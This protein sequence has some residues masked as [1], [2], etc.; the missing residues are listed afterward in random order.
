MNNDTGALAPAADIHDRLKHLGFE[1]DER[2]EIINKVNELI[3]A[4]WLADYLAS[5]P[6]DLKTEL[7]SLT[8][9]TV[10]TYISANQDRFPRID[11]NK[12]G[13]LGAE[14]LR[15]FYASLG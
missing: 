1:E 11:E 12:V 8:P 3:I 13:T 6:E 14:V 7:L 9:E 4:R 5:L 15:D 10:F 2:E